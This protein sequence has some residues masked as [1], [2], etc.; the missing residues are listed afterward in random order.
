[1]SIAIT[2]SHLE[3]ARDVVGYP[4][5]AVADL[6]ESK[7]SAAIGIFPTNVV[8]E[9]WRAHHLSGVV[10]DVPEDVAVFRFESSTAS[11][12]VKQELRLREEDREREAAEREKAK[13]SARASSR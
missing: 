5:E 7:T 6:V 11:F 1:M 10:G 3:R 12:H 9:P 4:T 2:P 13:R 8:E